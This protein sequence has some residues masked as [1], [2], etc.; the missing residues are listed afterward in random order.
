MT[1]D[2]TQQPE[3]QPGMSQAPQE[4]Q[5][6]QEP[7]KRPDTCPSCNAPL[8][9]VP[10]VSEFCPHCGHEFANPDHFGSAQ[11]HRHPRSLRDTGE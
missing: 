7:R 6:T 11:W 9:D 2:Q 8:A 4:S 1:D 10:D 3:V 5:E